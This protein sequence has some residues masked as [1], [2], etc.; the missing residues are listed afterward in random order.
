MVALLLLSFRCLVTVNVL[1]LFLTVLRVGMHYVIVVFPDNIHLLFGNYQKFVTRLMSSY[2][3]L[4]SCT[5]F[6]TYLYQIEITVGQA[7]DI[8]TNSSRRELLA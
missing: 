3:K 4:C 7:S 5:H 8:M 1:W 2:V 6:L